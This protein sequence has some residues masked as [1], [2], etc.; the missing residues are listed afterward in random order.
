[1][2]GNLLICG[3]RAVLPDRVLAGASVRIAG[4]Q[5]AA[6]REQRIKPFPG[7]TILDAEGRWLLPGLV[8]IHCDAIEKE[9]QPRPTV[10]L[11]FELALMEIDR[12]LALAGV[13]TIFH[14]VSF[15][16]GEGVRSNEVAAG[17]VR[18]I[19]RFA[20]GSTL[21]RHRVH[22]RFE[23][24][25]W[26]ALGMVEGLIQEGHVGMLSFMD[27]TP[28]QGQYRDP[29]RFVHYL[30]KTYWVGEEEAAHIVRQ[31]VEGRNRVSEG[32]L[33]KLAT[34]T[35]RADVP[36]AAHDL[37]SPEAVQRALSLG[38][39]IAE[40]PIS[41]DVA[42][43][44]TR[45]GLDVCVGAPNALR[46]CSHDGNLNAREAISA[47]AADLLC[48]DYHPSSLLQAP[49]ALAASDLLPFPRALAMATQH[50]ASAAGLGGLAGALETGGR[51]DLLLVSEVDGRPVVDVTIVGGQVVL[52]AGARKPVPRT[53][54]G[55]LDAS[56]A[57][58][59]VAAASPA[60]A[61]GLP[62][63]ARDGPME[64]DR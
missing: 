20:A 51:G 45:S 19:A 63:I 64:M 38:A 2:H 12:K 47:N 13:T 35:L 59:V 18:A 60:A 29:E 34:L 43:Y 21:V 54:R 33:R 49:F 56:P 5:I 6:I 44:A 42:L 16:S 15:G 30:R 57:A 36:V 39:T 10:R 1:M 26:Q 52:A 55:G 50:A 24:S 9:V 46:G 53:T 8:D 22:L 23:I 37:D 40:F 28:G 17:L 25:N 58:E 14:G 4:G 27:H 3:A 41:T 32:Q 61:A 62:A 31:K 11:P 7:E 48:S